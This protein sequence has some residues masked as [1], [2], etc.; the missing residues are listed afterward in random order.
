MNIFKEYSHIFIRC[1]ISFFALMLLTKLLGKKQ[2]SQLTLFDYITGITIG[3]IAASLAV[4]AQITLYHG[5]IGLLVWTLLPIAIS[6]I[7]LRNTRFKRLTD[8]SPSILI[9]NGKIVYDNLKKERFSVVDL[10]EELRLKDVFNVNDVEFAILE[11]SGKLSVQKKSQKQAVTPSDLN[12]PTKYYGLSA[13]LIIDGEIM[14]NHLINV[15]LNEEW[16]EAELQAQKIK[17]AN[18][19]ALAVLDS[20]GKLHIYLKSMS[21]KESKILE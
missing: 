21:V 13:N 5:I 20:D 3:S 12:I 1:V 14:H 17:S 2:I 7:T 8:G 10:L 11:T 6:K 15:K 4:D 18:E 16:L 19:V 9:Q